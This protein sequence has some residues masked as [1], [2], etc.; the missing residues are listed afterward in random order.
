MRVTNMYMV[1]FVQQANEKNQSTVAQLSQ[2]VPSGLA[3]SKPSDNPTAWIEAQREGRTDDQRRYWPGAAG[4]PRQDQRDRWRA[5]DAVAARLARRSP[6]KARARASRAMRAPMPRSRSTASCSRRS[7]PS[8]RRTSTARTCF[9]RHG[10]QHGA[11]RRERHVSRH[12]DDVGRVERER[13]VAR[14]ARRQRALDTGTNSVNII[15]TLGNL[16][17]ALSG[18]DVPGIQAQP[19]TQHRRLAARHDARAGRRHDGVAA[20]RAIGSSRCRPH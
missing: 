17:T 8:T 15:Q 19:A 9:L 4:R 10:R 12:L 3:V 20:I 6:S 13:H 16:A 18:N 11:V 1:T 2:E 14:L 7:P 5:V